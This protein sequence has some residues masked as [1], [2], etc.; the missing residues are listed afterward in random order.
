MTG[1]RLAA[2]S[3]GGMPIGFGLLLM[4]GSVLPWLQVPGFGGADAISGLETDGS[5]TVF[6]GLLVAILGGIVKAVRARLW[7]LIVGVV[8]S[9]LAL[10]IVVA[11]LVDLFGIT[12]RT[13]IEINFGIWVALLAA[14]GCVVAVAR[15]LRNV[16]NQDEARL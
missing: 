4:L 8:L 6:L 11:K 2:R 14:A 5:T 9:A 12:S 15:C 16:E 3:T 7:M 10:A 1:P 13:D